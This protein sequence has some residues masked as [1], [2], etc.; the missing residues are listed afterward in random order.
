MY[1]GIVQNFAAAP[2]TLKKPA[3]C[4]YA[5]API[6]G[7]FRSCAR[8][9]NS[10]FSSRYFTIFFAAVALIPEMWES[11]AVGSGIQIPRPRRS[12]SPPQHLL[13]PHPAVR[14]SYRADTAPLRW[15]WGR[16]SPIPPKGPASLRAMDTAERWVTS[17]SGNSSAA[18]LEAE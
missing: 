15:I 12:R 7:T 17:K 2:D 4:S 3:A 13:R 18:S 10:P 6:F 8:L 11:R 16:F 5:L 14:A 1:S 9:R